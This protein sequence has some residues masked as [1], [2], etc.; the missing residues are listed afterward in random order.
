MSDSSKCSHD[1]RCQSGL[2]YAIEMIRHDASFHAK[3]PSHDDFL[4]IAQVRSKEMEQHVAR[5]LAYLLMVLRRGRTVEI[6]SKGKSRLINAPQRALSSCAA[7]SFVRPAPPS[8]P[9]LRG[10]Q[11]RNP[12]APRREAR[13]I[14]SGTANAGC[15]A[16][17]TGN[18]R[19]S[20]AVADM[21]AWLS[22]AGNWNCMT[23][24]DT[25][26]GD[27][28]AAQSAPLPSRLTYKA[29]VGGGRIDVAVR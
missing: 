3:R 12:I 13:G 22:P 9:P 2:L 10:S 15:A 7:N 16:S 28:S 4:A 14:A 23:I 25:P 5:A 21:T 18:L 6:L 27:G 26:G 20:G 29:K 11:A 1:L 19:P 24:P 17:T 8:I